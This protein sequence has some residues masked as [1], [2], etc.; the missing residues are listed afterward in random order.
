MSSN[1]FRFHPNDFPEPL[2]DPADDFIMRASSNK[3][4][5]SPASYPRFLDHYLAG[6]S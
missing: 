3:P 5:R 1:I 6:R 4:A 2:V